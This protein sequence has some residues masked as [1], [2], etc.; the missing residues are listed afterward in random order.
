MIEAAS[1]M[2]EAFLHVL[3]HTSNVVCLEGEQCGICLEEY[4]TTSRE[5][6]VVEVAIRLPCN[7][8]VGSVCIVTWLTDHQ[9]CPICRQ[10]LFQTHP[11]SDLDQDIADGAETEYESDRDSSASDRDL[12]YDLGLSRQVSWISRYLIF[13]LAESRLLEERHLEWYIIV[14]GT[15]MGS[16]ITRNPRSPREIAEVAGLSASRLREAY[17]IVYPDR[18]ELID[19]HLSSEL[20]RLFDEAGPGPLNWPAPGNEVT[21]LEIESRRDLQM[22][23][24]RERC[25]QSCE[26]LEMGA[27]IAGLS[28]RIATRYFTAGLVVQ[29][30]T[31]EMTAASIYMASHMMR[32]PINSGRL[33]RTLR[34]D[35]S[36][37]RDAYRVAYNHQDVLRRQPQLEGP[38]AQSMDSLLRRIPFP[39]AQ[40]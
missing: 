10:E 13:N 6:G 33:A 38:R 19:T 22:Q 32:H 34:L 2:S 18:E 20:E 36:H 40:E 37:V 3:L 21:D 16:Y 9:T 39:S 1:E 27:A 25:E 11:R 12:Y 30:S 14:L 28:A 4:N 26:G 23:I 15:Y 17:D 24:F 7:H 29:L 5:S 8:V 35:E 31:T